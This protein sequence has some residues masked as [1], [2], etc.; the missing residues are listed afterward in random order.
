MRS[1][2]A[3]VD[4]LVSVYAQILANPGLLKLELMMRG[5]RVPDA[6]R[7]RLNGG[8]GVTGHALFGSAGDVDLVLPGGTW[9][10][11]PVTDGRMA[12]TPYALDCVDDA[13]TIRVDEDAS[14]T[15]RV[16]VRRPSDFFTRTTSTG[17]P[18]GRIGTV[19]G[20][21][22]A[23]SPSNRCTFL[24]DADRCRFCGV[25]QDG[26]THGGVPVDDVLEAIRI[27][28]A[29]NP[30]DM[31]Y[32]S[33]GHLGTSDGGVRFLEPY[34]A[35]IKKHFD[36]LVAVDALPPE[37]DGWIDRTYAMGVDAVSYNLEIFDAERFERVCP[38]PAREVGRAR[39]LD[40]L[41]YAA[42]V[43]PSGGVTCHL[44][45]GLEPLE[46]TR[47]GITALTEMGVLPVL[48]IYRPFKGRDM[49]RDADI[50]LF[51]PTLDELIALHTHLYSAVRARKLSLN[52]VRDIAIVTTPLEGRFFANDDSVWTSLQVRVM[53]SRVGRRTS[54]VLSDLRRHL[55]VRR[56]EQS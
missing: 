43:F 40:A 6:V 37:D 38:G 17:I 33:V 39:F 28:R 8:F 27:A 14:A 41:A 48:P 42:T 16:E 25:G 19:H 2:A 29:D 12:P 9:V 53:G 49:R 30:I 35:A 3:R 11:V 5:I 31:V 46:S 32:L 4:A 34:V 15:C 1:A 7:D 23:L 51:P 55:R 52:L 20:P 56:I 21:Y 26:A 47:A 45:V 10:S 24:T 22:L 50:E 54:T 36:I 44:I 13:F 18:Y